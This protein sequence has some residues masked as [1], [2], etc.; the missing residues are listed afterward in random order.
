M[1]KIKDIA[2][3]AGVSLS[4]VSIA[5]NGKPGLSVAT[6]E[7]I[8]TLAHE[9]NYQSASKKTHKGTLRFLKIA[10]HGNTVNDAHQLFISGYIDGMLEQASQAGFTLEVVSYQGISVEDMVSRESRMPPVS[11][12]VILGTE[13]EQHDFQPLRRLTTPF[14]IID[15]VNDFLPYDFI[16]MN[17]RSAVYKILQHFQRRGLT[18]IGLITSDAH[19]PNFKQ[20]EQA[21]IELISQTNLLFQ[22]HDIIRVNSTRDDACR[23][24]T[25]LLQDNHPLAE[26]YFCVNDII[27]SGCIKALKAHHI[28]VPERVSFIGFDDLPISAVMDPPLTTIQVFNSKIGAAAIEVLLKRLSAPPARASINVLI[29]GELIRRESVRRNNEPLNTS[30]EAFGCNRR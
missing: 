15:N 12:L 17:N 27:A 25:Q 20:R 18:H 10:L 29:C 21:F 3:R 6:R 16:N 19:T 23:T 9:L 28:A 13:F 2:Q 5:L 14:V 11:G 22:P 30:A 8:L 4:A 26:G 7:R 24:M 1:A